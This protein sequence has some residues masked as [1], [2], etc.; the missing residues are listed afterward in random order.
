MS[1]LLQLQ[2]LVE[3]TELSWAVSVGPTTDS[4]HILDGPVQCVEGKEADG[5]GIRQGMMRK[6]YPFQLLKEKRE[7]G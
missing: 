3:F 6:A 1:G 4:S 7:P 5:G 2:G